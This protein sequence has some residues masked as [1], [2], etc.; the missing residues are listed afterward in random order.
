MQRLKITI[1]AVTCAWL[2]GI[3]GPTQAQTKTITLG[4]AVQLTGALAN[5]GRYYQDA[6]HLAVDQINA[7]G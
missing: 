4:A 1:L 5:T 3:A 2:A 7:K 6:Y